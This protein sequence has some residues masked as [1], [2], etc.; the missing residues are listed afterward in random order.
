MT[1]TEHDFE[2]CEHLEEAVFRPTHEA[3]EHT[4]LTEVSQKLYERYKHAGETDEIPF[5]D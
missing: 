3:K 4:R 5:T 1:M 2:K